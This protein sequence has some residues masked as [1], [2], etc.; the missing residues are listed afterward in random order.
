M[1]HVDQIIAGHEELCKEHLIPIL[2]EIQAK[3]GYVSRDA[4]S[5]VAEAVGVPESRV[6]GVATFYNQFRFA[7]KGTHVIE[8]CRGHRLPREAE[9]EARAA[10][11]A[12]AEPE[13]QRQL[14]RRQVHRHHG[15]LPRG[16]LDRPGHQI[17]WRVSTAISTLEKLDRLLDTVAEGA[18]PCE[19]V[20]S[21]PLVVTAVPTGRAALVATHQVHSEG[22]VCHEDEACK[23]SRQS[24]LAK[25]RRGGEGT[26]IFVGAGTCVRANGSTKVIARIVEFLAQNKIAAEIIETGCVGYCQRELFVDVQ[27]ADSPRI[28]YA[29]INP[30]NIDQLL[31]EVFIKRTCATASCSRATARPAP[32]GRTSPRSTAPTSSKRQVKV[33]LRNAGIVDPSNLDAA[34]AAGAFKSAARALCNMTPEEVCNEVLASGLRGRGG[35]W[36]PHRPEVE[37]RPSDAARAEVPHLQR[38]RGRPRGL[39]GPRADRERSA[40]SM[41]RGHDDRRLRHRGQQGRLRLHAAPSTRWRSQ[42]LTRSHRPQLQARTGLHRRQHHGQR[43][44]PSTVH[45][46]SMGAGAFVCGEE[47]ALMAQHRG[48]AA[49]CRVPVRPIPRRAGL[50]AKAH[51]ASTTWRPWPTSRWSCDKGAEGYAGRWVLATSGG[52]QDL[53]PV[54][55]TRSSNAGLVEVAMGT[56]LAHQSIFDM[57]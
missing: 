45:T 8:V 14:S 57:R 51:G 31:D 16:L 7:P 27:L 6:Y 18:G 44:Q 42:R 25:V 15:G 3:E 24:L 38:R 56:K 54:S 40:S 53:R 12:Q 23:K 5:K 41:H 26:L 22:P 10:S 30:G 32:T 46:S 52:H 47:T 37:H 11:A 13:A 20:V 36:L 17:G 29:D 21:S 55:G 35:R 34:L 28:A 43:V 2:Q 19:Q 50:F 1:C 4:M 9:L 49:E 39:H 33:V 48:S